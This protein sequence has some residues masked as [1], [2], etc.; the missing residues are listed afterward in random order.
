MLVFN[1]ENHTY[2]LDGE[3]I[4]SATTVIGKC[5]LN[6]FSH[7]HPVKLA[8]LAERGTMVHKITEMY[9][10][11]I[12]DE[13]T[14]DPELS[15]YLDAW[16][17]LKKDFKFEIVHNEQKM[18]NRNYMYAGTVDRIIMVDGCLR[19]LDIKTGDYKLTHDL[20]L[21]GYS[22]LDSDGINMSK[23]HGYVAC[24]KGD[25]KWKI[26]KTDIAPGWRDFMSVLNVYK[27][28][29]KLGVIKNV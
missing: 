4:P 28:K 1:E 19:P 3:L 17:S 14:V 22:Y 11:G 2:T 21:A 18:Y 26:H 6:D 15:G 8:Q 24:I 10:D 7:I 27:L 9:D 25:G 16:K 12:L 29:I 13:S 23:D 20:Q 5:G